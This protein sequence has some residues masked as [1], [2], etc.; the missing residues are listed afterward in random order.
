LDP[1]QSKKYFRAAGGVQGAPVLLLVHMTDAAPIVFI[2]DDD[3]SIRESLEP[4]LQG[5]GW[6]PQ[7]CGSAQEFLRVCRPRVPHCLV[8]DVGLPGLSGLELQSMISDRYEMP[9]IFMSGREDVPTC[10]RAMKA[11]AIEFLTKP[12]CPRALLDAIRDAL[13]RSAAAIFRER[14]L[15]GLRKLY[16]TLTPRERQ[17][18]ELVVEGFLNKQIGGKLEISEITVKAHR[19]SVMRKMAAASLADLVR[20]AGKLNITAG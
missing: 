5:S 18:M 12:F 10:A 4:L 1:C 19:G 16:A 11:G 15:C 13:V 14:E 3:V 2:V 20:M 6:L 8:L 7:V 9:V 17:V